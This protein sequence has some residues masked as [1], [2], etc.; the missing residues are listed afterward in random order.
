MKK[1][2][3]ECNFWHCSV[4][5]QVTED[6]RSEVFFDIPEER[7]NHKLSGNIKQEYVLRECRE[8]VKDFVVATAWAYKAK[9]T[10]LNDLWVNYQ[11]VGEFNPPHSHGGDLS[12]VIFHEIPYLIEHEM[13][14]YPD[15][16]GGSC[17]GHFS[18]QYTN[19]Y[20]G[21]VNSMLPVD[22]TFEDTMFMFDAKLKHA[23]Y[24]FYSNPEM[25]RITVA[26]NLSFA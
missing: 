3:S 2:L 24:P 20:G 1:V 14:R 11:A 26:G 22:Q 19:P 17:A 12:F 10:K 16:N 25:H 8:S 6:I 4:P 5:Q 15:V 7:Y 13:S 9:P 23:V 18:F 21:I